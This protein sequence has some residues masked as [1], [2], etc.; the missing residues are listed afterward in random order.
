[1]RKRPYGWPPDQ[2][3]Y[4][5]DEALAH[6]RQALPR[7]DQAQRDWD[8]RI[9][10]L[11]EG[12]TRTER[13]A[14]AALVAGSCQ[15]AGPTTCRAF[16]SADGAIATR[17][18]S[19]RTLNALAAALSL[20]D[21]RLGGPRDVEQHDDQGTR[22]TSGLKAGRAATSTLASASTPCA[23][24]STAWLRTAASSGSPA[25]SSCS[26]TTCRGAI[27]LAAL[28]THTLDLRVHPRQRRTGRGRADSPADRAPMPRCAR[29]RT[30]ASSG[31]PMPTRRAAAWKAGA[32]NYRGPSAL[33]LSRQAVPNLGDGER[34]RAGVLARRVRD[35]R[36]AGRPPDVII[37]ATGS[38]VS[39]GG[40]RRSYAGREG[41]R[42]RVVSMPCWELFEEQPPAVP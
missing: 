15:K 22:D 31:L 13:R 28:S 12:N 36:I 20:A 1:M 34:L 11:R 2:H 16:S 27:R 39:P 38:E 33:V 6:F 40:R 3:F 7:G 29:C 17:V 18:A 10:A 4:V 14:S 25:R 19:G 41:V 37:I 30:C 24:S 23:E 26:R 8:A 35:Q 9:D 21:R 32:S 5:P 42:A